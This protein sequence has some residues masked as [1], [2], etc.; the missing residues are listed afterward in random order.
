M[1]QSGSYRNR[2]S[3]KYEDSD[4]LDSEADSEDHSKPH[5]HDA[6]NIKEEN[7]IS[8]DRFK[9]F[10]E[11]F[12]TLVK[13]KEVMTQY[14]L[15]EMMITYNSKLAVTITKRSDREYYVKMYNLNT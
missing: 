6:Y 3:V 9:Y 7:I 8:N 1:S 13:S 10:S 5:K 4:S 2:A 12:S 14:P 15:V 11:L